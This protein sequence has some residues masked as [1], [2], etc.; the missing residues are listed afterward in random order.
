MKEIPRDLLGV[1]RELFERIN[2][3]RP[4]RQELARRV[5]SW[6]IAVKNLLCANEF[7]KALSSGYV[8]YLADFIVEDIISSCHCQMESRV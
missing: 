5:I 6:L 4:L 2:N 1:H 7:F 3:D 8:E